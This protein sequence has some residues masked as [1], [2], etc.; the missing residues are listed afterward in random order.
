MDRFIEANHWSKWPS[1]TPWYLMLRVLRLTFHS[2]IFLNVIV[3][4]FR[5]V[6]FVV[7]RSNCA[8]TR[9]DQSHL[10]AR[11]N[12][13]VALLKSYVRWPLGS[14]F[15]HCCCS[16]FDSVGLWSGMKSLLITSH[17]WHR[18]N[19]CIRSGIIKIF[20]ECNYIIGKQNHVVRCTDSCDLSVLTEFNRPWISC[21]M[22]L[23]HI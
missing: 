22:F 12:S 1:Q 11:W 4:S 10:F 13:N 20:P 5:T 23:R 15:D 7:Q 8:T 3:S 2:G 9:V 6:I 17:N 16:S 18:A 14:C 21:Y 19:F